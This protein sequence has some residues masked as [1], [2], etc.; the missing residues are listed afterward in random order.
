M[1]IEEIR[2]KSDDD[3]RAELDES[4]VELMNLR[5]RWATRQISNVY[6]LKKVRKKIARILTVLKERELGIVNAY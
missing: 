1:F 6:E 2:S 4:Y 5:F 3:L